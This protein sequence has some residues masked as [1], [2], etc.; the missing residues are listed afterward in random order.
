MKN[1]TDSGVS[2]KW[3]EN[4]A[5]MT[6]LRRVLIIPARKLDDIIKKVEEE[7]SK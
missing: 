4:D 1:E 7:V 2:G 5:E 6:P 3:G